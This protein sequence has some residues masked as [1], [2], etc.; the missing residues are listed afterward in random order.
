MDLLPE[1]VRLKHKVLPIAQNGNQY[2]IAMVDPDDLIATDALKIQLKSG[3]LKKLVCTADDFEFV[4]QM[5][6]APLKEAE[7]LPAIA[8]VEKAIKAKAKSASPSKVPA[9]KHLTALFHDDEEDDD[10]LE[11]LP[12]PAAP[13]A[14]GKEVQPQSAA[15][16]PEPAAKKAPETIN[17]NTR[18]EAAAPEAVP[19]PDSDFLLKEQQL[20]LEI[21]KTFEIMETVV[22]SVASHLVDTSPSLDQDPRRQLLEEVVR[23]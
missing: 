2:T 10:L 6:S 21:P 20:A 19:S 5:M 3:Q 23:I 4:S 16:L 14:N 11:P 22:S 15:P 9:R 18:R 17:T 8:D 1:E 13:P 7:P 12:T